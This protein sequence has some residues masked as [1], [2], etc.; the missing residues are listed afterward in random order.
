RKPNVVDIG[1]RLPSMVPGIGETRDDASHCLA[2]ITADAPMP[3]RAVLPRR[4]TRSPARSPPG[5]RASCP[6]LSP[7]LPSPTAKGPSASRPANRSHPPQARVL[8]RHAA[9]DQRSATEISPPPPGGDPEIAFDR[10]AEH[11]WL[12][13][14][15]VIIT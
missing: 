3:L 13:T 9:T 4:V 15:I 1:C 12:R 6:T 14:F 11:S 5:G 7:P 8:P 2:C 10:S